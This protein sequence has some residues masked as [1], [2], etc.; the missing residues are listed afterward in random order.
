M[1]FLYMSGKGGGGISVLQTSIFLLFLLIIYNLIRGSV[2]VFSKETI[3]HQNHN[4]NL[5]IV[6]TSE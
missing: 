5:V 1:P 2:L 3:D 6:H 4:T